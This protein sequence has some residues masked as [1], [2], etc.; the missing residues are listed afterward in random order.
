MNAHT[1]LEGVRIYVEAPRHAVLFATGAALGAALLLAVAILGQRLGVQVF[2][3]CAP[4]VM[5]LWWAWRSAARARAPIATLE[6]SDEGMTARTP[7]GAATV[8]SWRAVLRGA[9][10][11]TREGA[12]AL[13]LRLND[14]RLI[15]VRL[16]SDEAVALVCARFRRA[17]EW[18]ALTVPLRGDVDL[19]RWGVIL[20]V[21]AVVA[22]LPLAE[23]V[24]RA[25]GLGSGLFVWALGVALAARLVFEMSTARVTVGNDGVV[26]LLLG[27]ERFIPWSRVADVD[28]NEYGVVLSLR[29]GEDVTLP[30]LSSAMVR[31][32]RDASVARAV[33]LR[34]ALHDRLCAGLDA[35]RTR[36]DANDDREVLLDRQGRSLDAWRNAVHALLS[37]QRG[38]RRAWLDADDAGRVI[39]DPSRPIERRIAA[40]WALRAHD[41]NVATVR[42]RVAI[43]AAA[44]EAVREALGLAS[45]GELDEQTLDRVIEATGGVARR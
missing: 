37:G 40:V 13:R 14:G 27:R 25:V 16:P 35:W 10:V 8:V 21:L 39:A 29:D 19:G 15:H 9:V 22:P 34:D 7:T 6:L 43:D 12:E 33:Q 45:R 1:T 24:S 44:S 32:E 18:R 17:T 41:A 30:L 42:V 11:P 23:A 36:G 20:S 3:G 28:W 38:Y 26:V 4:I 5:V 31:A 2:L